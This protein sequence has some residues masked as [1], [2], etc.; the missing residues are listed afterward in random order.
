VTTYRSAPV[1]QCYAPAKA[2]SDAANALRH[3]REAANAF[4]VGYAVFA[5]LNGRPKRLATFAPP[6]I[7]I[8]LNR[9]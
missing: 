2:F 4:G 3:A 7:P 9:S 5:C 1:M 8:H 6:L